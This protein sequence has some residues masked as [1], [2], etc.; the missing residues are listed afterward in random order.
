MDNIDL[1]NTYWDRLK[2]YVTELRVDARWVLRQNGSNKPVGSL[3]I[4]SH[5]DLPPG[6]LR[7]IFTYVTSIKAKTKEE[8]LKTIEDY[9]ME[10]TELEV[11]SISED[12]K[13]ETQEFKEPFPELEKMF[14]VEIFET[15]KK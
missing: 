11:Y 4:A 15:K 8:K 9:Q 12:T 13:T 7:A 3:R 10:I 14:G 5:P 2:G 6:Y 1:N